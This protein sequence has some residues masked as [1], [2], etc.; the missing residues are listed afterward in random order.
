MPL[1]IPK[2]G[3]ERVVEAVEE[4]VSVAAET[5]VV[6]NETATP[7]Y[8]YDRKKLAFVCPLGDPS[9]PDITKR[10]GKDG[11]EDVKTTSTIVGYKFE[12]LEDLRI[13]DCGTNEKFKKEPMNYV[14]SDKW[15]D[16]KAGTVVCLT[17]FETALLLSQPGFNGGCEGGEKAVTCS[18]AF[19]APKS[20]TGA[21]SVSA[22]M[23]TPRVSLRA[24]Q[25]SIKDHIIEDVLTHT[26]VKNA[27]GR[28]SKVRNLKPGFEKWAPL[29]QTADRRSVSSGALKAKKDG[30][31]INENAVK[32]LKFVENAKARAKAE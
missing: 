1:T 15:I 23:E 11:K 27:N 28:V 20:K 31:T 9:N 24:V 7:K 18:Y 2:R 6:E 12:V 4:T 26:D 21:V 29:A 25:G 14:D 22:M 16:V 5:Q 13:P 3:E 10:V 17:P 32:F 8:G 30:T 19:K